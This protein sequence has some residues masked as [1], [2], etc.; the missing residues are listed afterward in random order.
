MVKMLDRKLL[1]DVWQM[2]G[3]VLAIALVVASGIVGYCGSL[4]TYDS[5]LWLQASHYERARFAHVFAVGKRAP[6]G[7]A[8]HLA[9]IPGVTETETTLAFDVLVDVPATSEPL[10]GRLIALPDHG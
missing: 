8:D 6:S 2:R 9:E 10:T 7:L 1:R 5:L 3:Q 4:S